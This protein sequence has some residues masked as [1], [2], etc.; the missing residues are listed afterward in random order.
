[1]RKVCLKNV[2]TGV[3]VARTIHNLD[4]V[5]LLAAGTRLTH[6]H[7]EKLSCYG[8]TEIFIDDPISEG[9]IVPELIKE[10]IITDVKSQVK[11]M[12]TSPSIKVSVDTKRIGEIVDKLITSILE[13]QEIIVNLC[14]IRSIDEYT[15][16]HSVNVCVISMVTGIGI[17][18][19]G[20]DLRQLGIGALLHDVGK[21][22]VDDA[23]LKKS[24]S[25]TIAEYEEVKKHARY[26][27]EILKRSE[28]ISETACEIVLHHHERLDGS[29]YPHKLKN[30]DIKIQA[31]IVAI[32]DTYDALTTDRVYRRKMMP[33]D[34]LDYLLSLGNKHFDKSLLDTFVRHIAYYPVGTAVILNS[35]EKGLVS[36]YK[37]Y[38]PHRP[39]VR[40]VMDKNGHI[41]Q[42]CREVD[43]SKKLDYR[44]VSIW[45]V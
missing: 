13:N 44:V 4:G 37:P 20:D 45:D 18:M 31:R 6:E 25:L 43:L 38:F 3:V 17:G 10:E 1:M 16:S 22:M 27:Y 23:I 29:G 28:S 35:G 33:H 24:A 30:N 32:A 34:V 9:I 21:V 39:V 40:V 8:I 12:M 11:R 7:K 42:N 15:Y 26:G 14:D 5:V 41:L 19:K 2:Q 36:V